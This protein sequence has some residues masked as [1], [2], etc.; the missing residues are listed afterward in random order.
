MKLH[1]LSEISS[2]HP[3]SHWGPD[4]PSPQIAHGSLFLGSQPQSTASLGSIFTG[5]QQ[6]LAHMAHTADYTF[7]GILLVASHWCQPKLQYLLDRSQGYEG[8][9]LL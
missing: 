5:R 8:L 4:P 1:E 7:W 2:L 9:T 3:V 6:L